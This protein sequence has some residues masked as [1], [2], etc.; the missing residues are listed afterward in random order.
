MVNFQGAAKHFSN[1]TYIY[2]S[3][4]IF[5]LLKYVLMDFFVCSSNIF[6][7]GAEIYFLSRL[8]V[9]ARACDIHVY[10]ARFRE[11]LHKACYCQ[12]LALST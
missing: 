3:F 12:Q 10:C 8:C 11:C 7:K 9:A 1:Y 6:C 4:F 2:V 5:A